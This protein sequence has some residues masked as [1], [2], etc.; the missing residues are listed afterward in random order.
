MLS[1]RSHKTI[2]KAINDPNTPAHKRPIVALFVD[3]ATANAIRAV[4]NIVPSIERLT[5]PDLSVIVSPSTTKISGV[6]KDII[7]IN[8]DSK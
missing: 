1:F 7:V 4:N 6:L 5:T 2:I 3:T 8:D